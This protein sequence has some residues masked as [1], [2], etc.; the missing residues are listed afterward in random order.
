[1]Q[2]RKQVRASLVFIAA[3]VVPA[4]GAESPA[5]PTASYSQSTHIINSSGFGGSPTACDEFNNARAGAVS[6]FVT[7]P[8]IHLVLRSGTCNAPGQ[9]LAEKDTELVNV[10]APAGAN[11][12]RVS[13][14]NPSGPDTPYMLRLTYWQ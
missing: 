2:S 11:H 12:V 4:C 5:S 3:L 9:T 7:P 1:M 6:V 13:N 14:P 8:S 10:N